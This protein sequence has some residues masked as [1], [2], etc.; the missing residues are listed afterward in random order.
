MSDKSDESLLMD[1]TR[2]ALNEALKVFGEFSRLA[3]WR[4]LESEFNISQTGSKPL[5][6]VEV[7]FALKQMFGEGH[8]IILK[9]FE[10]ELARQ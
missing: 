8:V 1:K 7:E 3:A 2:T 9:A 4:Q 6:M 10:Q 5:S